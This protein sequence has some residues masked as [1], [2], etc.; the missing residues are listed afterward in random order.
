MSTSVIEQSEGLLDKVHREHAAQ[1]RRS[2][3]QYR[4]L[5]LK[6]HSATTT[7]AEKLRSLL[8]ELDLKP[9]DARR[10]L[11]ILREAEGHQS[12]V[13]ESDAARQRY[14][15][16]HQKLSKH[17]VETKKIVK[18]RRELEAD[19]EDRTL[20]ALCRSKDCALSAKLLAKLTAEN[21][22]LFGVAT[23]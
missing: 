10:H 6:N 8:D 14:D 15:E 7:D 13:A 20:T 5:L 9:T 18:Q 3:G 17:K 22:E 4:E 23:D 1:R 16:V 21:A 11:A 2:F 19:L 12:T